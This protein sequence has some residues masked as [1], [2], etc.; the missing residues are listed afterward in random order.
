MDYFAPGYKPPLPAKFVKSIN[1]VYPNEIPM[2]G[3]WGIFVLEDLSKVYLLSNTI[4]GI[5]RNEYVI[6]IPNK[7]LNVSLN[8]E[9]VQKL[10]N[11]NNEKMKREFS[12]M[13]NN[14]IH[15]KRTKEE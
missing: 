1:D 12:R 15:M 11:E 5:K 8:L 7:E 6:D 2:D 10:I 9:E 3:S 14:K 13:I 4:E